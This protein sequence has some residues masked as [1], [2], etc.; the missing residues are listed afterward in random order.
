MTDGASTG[1]LTGFSAT[2]G[3]N[4]AVIA[5]DL[6]VI[7][8][9]APKTTILNT[10]A[11]TKYSGSPGPTA[12]NFVGAVTSQISDTATV[13]TLLPANAKV[14][15]STSLTSAT[16]DTTHAVIGEIATY[17]VT[18]TVPEGT[19]PGAHLIDTMD[20]GLDFVDVTSVTSSSGVTIDL[21]G[22][23]VILTPSTA[24]AGLAV[25]SN[26]RLTTSGG[27]R[28]VDFNLGNVTIPTP[29]TAALIQSRSCTAPSS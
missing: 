20:V 7:S 12:P 28:V 21:S 1:S 29:A 17:T 23:P 5:Y 6:Q 8:T 19:T 27:K 26:P 14:L 9:V 4:I 11:L 10:A 15:T 2:T 18:V 13:T 3:A 25:G 22:P 16:N 24:N